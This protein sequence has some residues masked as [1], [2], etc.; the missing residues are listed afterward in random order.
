MSNRFF[1]V[2]IALTAAVVLNF[3]DVTLARGHSGTASASHS[4]GGH[5]A[6][7]G[8]SGGMSTPSH[9]GGNAS[10]SHSGGERSSAGQSFG[11]FSS[12]SS[13]SVHVGGGQSHSSHFVGVPHSGG[14][15]VTVGNS[16]SLHSGSMSRGTVHRSTTPF[17]AKNHTD[18]AGGNVWHGAGARIQTGGT[19]TAAHSGSAFG[20]GTPRIGHAGSGNSVT[21]HGNGMHV[22]SAGGKGTNTGVAVSSHSFVARHASPGG[23]GSTNGHRAG[24]LGNTSFGNIQHGQANQNH[25]H[26]KSH[27]ASFSRLNSYG[28][29][30]GYARGGHHSGWSGGNNRFFYGYGSPF[31]GYGYGWGG[32]FGAGLYGLGSYGYCGSGYGGW[33]Y[34]GLGYAGLGYGG[35]GYGSYCGPGYYAYDPYGYGWGTGG[36]GPYAGNIGYTSD[37][38]ASLYPTTSTY[39]STLSTPVSTATIPVSDAGGPPV[40]LDGNQPASDESFSDKG[41][42]AFKGGDYE[43]AVY[44]WRHAA[45]DD[46]ENGTVVMLL[47][48]ALFATGKFDEAAGAT[49][50]AMQLLPKEQ[51]GVVVANAQ[52]LYGNYQDYTTQLRALES[53][54]KE[55]PDNPA[56][57]F[58]A[59]F[60]YGYL[61][62]SRDAVAQLDK[63]LK[64][65][66]QD[67]GAKLLRDEM[68]A[69]L[70]GAVTEPAALLTPEAP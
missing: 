61:G 47:G 15:A 57:R 27:V 49:Q 19:F 39:A 8:H 36:Y 21:V 53:A 18:S 48:Q 69:K 38:Y 33:G 45:I 23:F 17:V 2:C 44:A 37:L 66:P 51:W 20:S 5:S 58:L 65:A 35:W 9:S 68:R 3:P 1:F 56:Q 25:N 28:S 10:H 41:E 50:A 30:G 54:V 42:I 40:I 70:A 6:A 31:Y 16:P 67:Q 32:L 29:F 34:G 59:G 14:A 62:F 55:K 4:S 60:H 43:G 7:G 64:L 24:G 22:V 26:G 46:P 12:G 52:D 13:S 11:G 63:T